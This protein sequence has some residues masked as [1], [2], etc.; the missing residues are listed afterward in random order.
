M[1]HALN[2]DDGTGMPGYCDNL[3]WEDVMV[4]ERNCRTFV[5]RDAR[6]NRTTEAICDYLHDH[7]KGRHTSTLASVVY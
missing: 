6:I 7:P 2:V 1:Q 5:E 3:W 4:L